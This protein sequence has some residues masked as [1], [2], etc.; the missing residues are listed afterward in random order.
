MRNLIV[1]AVA[2][3]ALAWGQETD[4]G[5]PI[6]KRGGPA[7]QREKPGEAP[8]PAQ[9]KAGPVYKEITVDE[10]G[11]PTQGVGEVI[12]AKHRNGSVGTA[13]LKFIG[14]YTKFADF[15][16]PS[17]TYENPFSGMIPR[18][19]RLNTFKPDTDAPPTTGDETPF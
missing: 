12:I 8:P 15:D 17:S 7:T 19:S 6:L 13:K 11:M 18:E 10:E 5:R 9:P 3:T 2:L 4:P 14:K 16:A 1:A